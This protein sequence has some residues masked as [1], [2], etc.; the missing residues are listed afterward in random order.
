MGDGFHANEICATALLFLLLSLLPFYDLCF[1]SLFLESGQHACRWGLQRQDNDWLVLPR[2][3]PLTLV[4]D[5]ERSCFMYLD[6]PS[7]RTGLAFPVVKP[8]T[9]LMCFHLPQ[10]SR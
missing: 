9:H 5:Y 3:S 4:L 2:L 10:L 7:I 6:S 8:Y 1:F